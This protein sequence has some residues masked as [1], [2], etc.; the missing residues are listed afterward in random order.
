M[1][2][3]EEKKKTRTPSRTR[4][5]NMTWH[6]TGAGLT[7]AAPIPPPQLGPCQGQGHIPVAF[8]PP[9]LLALLWRP[10]V[11][12]ISCPEALRGWLLMA[13]RGQGQAE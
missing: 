10:G 5:T 11:L 8:L 7:P 2:E 9:L 1:K 3:G 4:C 13:H 12:L 6:G